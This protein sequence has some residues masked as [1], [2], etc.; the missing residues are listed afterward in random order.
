M[1]KKN[2]VAFFTVIYPQNEKFT[3]DFLTSLNNQTYSKFDLIIVNDNTNNL[4]EKLQKYPNLNPIIF[5]L[6]GTPTKIRLNGLKKLLKLN[7]DYIIFGDCDDYF[8]NNRIKTIIQYLKKGIDLLGHDVTLINAKNTCIQNH[9]FYPRLKHTQHIS[10]ED[11]MTHNFLGLTNT[12][13]SHTLLK[14]VILTDV[15][16]IALDWYLF[17]QALLHNCKAIFIKDTLTA[18]R[19]HENSLVGLNQIN[20][21]LIE[22]G[23]KSKYLHYNAMLK[24]KKR[25]FKNLQYEYNHLYNTFTSCTKFKK[26][27]IKEAFNIK[28]KSPFWWETITTLKGKFNE[29]SIR[30]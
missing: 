21:S 24:L 6:N 3:I 14:K 19:Q 4:S 17:S 8:N 27:Y 10:I 26:L 15:N 20:S 16:V 11:I 5:N 28:L 12:A 13:I 9:F 1:V 30:K 29:D 7:H 23:L 18:Y 2:S 25:K 22:K